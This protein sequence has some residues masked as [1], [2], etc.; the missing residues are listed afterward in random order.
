MKRLLL[1][2]LLALASAVPAASQPAVFGCNKVYSVNQGATS[3]AKIISGAA[4]SA[5]Q[6]CGIDV[7][8]GA[9]GS[10]TIVSYGTGVNCGTG[11]VVLIPAIVLGINGVFVDHVAVP[12]FPVPSVNASGVPIDLCLNTTGTG[13][14][15]IMIF[16]AQF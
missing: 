6:I 2:L 8:A 14:T 11:N 3:I 7:N 10:S 4:G 15:T 13:P 1:A 9:A 5:I 16:Y 12:H